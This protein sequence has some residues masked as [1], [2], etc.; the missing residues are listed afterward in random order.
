MDLRQQYQTIYHKIEKIQEQNQKLE[1]DLQVLWWESK[2]SF[3]I[4]LKK[5]SCYKIIIQNVSSGEQQVMNL[6]LSTKSFIT[7][8]MKQLL[9]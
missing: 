3:S 2:K 5:F 6:F 9:K 1:D 8:S 7:W 4:L